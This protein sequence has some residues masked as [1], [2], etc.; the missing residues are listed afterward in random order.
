MFGNVRG[1]RAGY[2]PVSGPKFTRALVLLAAAAVY[3]LLISLPAYH[4]VLTDARGQVLLSLPVQE[5][6]RFAV[7]YQHSVHQTPVVEVFQVTSRGELCLVGSEFSTYGVGT[8]FLPGE[9]ELK[10]VNGRFVLEGMH[11]VFPEVRLQPHG[12]TRHQLLYRGRGYALLDYVN[13]G[14][15]VVLQVRPGKL[16]QLWQDLSKGGMFDEP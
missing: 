3:L 7:S 12:L 13:S 10:E 1:K 14:A 8:P 11:R 2:L 16:K 15:V 6:E 4:L 5:E 9:G